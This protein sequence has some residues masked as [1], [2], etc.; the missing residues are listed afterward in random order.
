MS[1]DLLANTLSRLGQYKPALKVAKEAV[2][3]HRALAAVATA[4]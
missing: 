3:A 2:D 4:P 1:L